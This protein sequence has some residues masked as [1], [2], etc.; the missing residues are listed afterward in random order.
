LVGY[1]DKLIGQFLE[2]LIVGD[3]RFELL[4]LFS[5]DALGELLALDVTL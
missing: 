4:G 1:G 2:A 5:G 3:E